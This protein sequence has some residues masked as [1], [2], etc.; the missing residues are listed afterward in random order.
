MNLFFLSFLTVSLF[1]RISLTFVLFFSFTTT[2][3]CLL[4]SLCFNFIP[5]LSFLSFSY[6]HDFS[7]SHLHFLSSFI[8]YFISLLFLPIHLCREKFPSPH[9]FLA[10][11]FF[12]LNRRPPPLLHLQRVPDEASPRRPGSCS[13]NSHRTIS[14][15]GY[16]VWRRW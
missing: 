4:S 3:L 12:L 8:F 2:M 7:L 13:W 9:L 16:A 14:R 5:F 10:P 6:S 15:G 11:P 1:L